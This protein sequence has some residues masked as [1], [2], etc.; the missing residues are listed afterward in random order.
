MDG[1]WSTLEALAVV[2]LGGVAVNG[3][4]PGE[5]VT[6]PWEEADEAKLVQAEC[7]RHMVACLQ[8]LDPFAA[9]RTLFY[10]ALSSVF[11]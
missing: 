3:T 6:G 2:A 7:A 8:E 9:L 1:A 5:V 10:T 4:A 11:G